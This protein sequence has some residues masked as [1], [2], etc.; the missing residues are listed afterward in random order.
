MLQSRT[1]RD[2]VGR[3]ATGVTVVTCA[4]DDGVPHG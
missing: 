1:G 3:F 2:A 4:K